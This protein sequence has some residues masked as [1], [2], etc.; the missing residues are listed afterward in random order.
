[1]FPTI[2]YV[3][4]L[5]KHKMQN[6]KNQNINTEKQAFSWERKTLKLLQSNGGRFALT[7]Q[8]GSLSLE[9]YLNLLVVMRILLTTTL[10]TA[11]VS[12]LQ[13]KIVNSI[14]SVFVSS[15]TRLQICE[16]QLGLFCQASKSG[17]L[18][19]FRCALDGCKEHKVL[20]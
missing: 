1:M 18:S 5:E 13:E 7:R 16:K 19:G 12:I 2:M 17:S 4:H 15:I 10:H 8:I 11:Q 6:I 20:R 3:L 14:P 9:R